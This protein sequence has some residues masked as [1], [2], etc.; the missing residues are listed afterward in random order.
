M[1]FRVPANML[2]V[3]WATL[4]NFQKGLPVSKIVNLVGLPHEPTDN[5]IR[6]VTYCLLV[7]K[8]ATISEQFNW[9]LECMEAATPCAFLPTLDFVASVEV[10][11]GRFNRIQRISTCE[12]FNRIIEEVQEQYNLM[13]MHEMDSELH[14]L[15]AKHWDPNLIDLHCHGIRG[16]EISVMERVLAS[17]IMKIGKRQ[18]SLREL[19]KAKH[20]YNI[21]KGSLNRQQYAEG[22]VS[23]LPDDRDMRHTPIPIDVR[24]DLSREWKFFVDTHLK[25]NYEEVG[26]LNILRS[27]VENNPSLKN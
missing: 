20:N 23:F 19:E 26:V 15:N 11:S 27:Q 13:V 25:E 16:L 21:V 10:P 3:N 18:K 7:S 8:A 5:D 2:F 1:S 4:K 24:G 14:P 9:A 22:D 17:G 12:E 6:R